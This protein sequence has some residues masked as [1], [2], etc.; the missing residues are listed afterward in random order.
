MTATARCILSLA[1]AVEGRLGWRLRCEP[2]GTRGRLLA[3]SWRGEAISRDR[4]ISLTNSPSVVREHSNPGIDGGANA[5]C[6][7]RCC[8][9]LAAGRRDSSSAR[10]GATLRD[11]TLLHT[12]ASRS[13]RAFER[14]YLQGRGELGSGYFDVDVL[15]NRRG[16]G[17]VGRSY[18]DCGDTPCISLQG[19]YRAVVFA[20]PVAVIRRND[21]RASLSSRGRAGLSRHRDLRHMG[22]CYGR[23]PLACTK[24][25]RAMASVQSCPDDTAARLALW[26]RQVVALALCARRRGRIPSP[27]W[28]GSPV[29]DVGHSCFTGPHQPGR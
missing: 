19:R 9:P 7:P 10:L 16:G 6:N 11:F 20:A 18:H 5:G 8:G 14:P 3:P 29:L 17:T 27:A 22:T 4:L 2:S 23:I 12:S 1:R 26:R 21:V 13:F 24:T 28:A 15:E 25:S